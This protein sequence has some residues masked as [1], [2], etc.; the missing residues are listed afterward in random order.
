MSL[1]E[2]KQKQQTRRMI[3]IQ[4]MKKERRQA[5]TTITYRINIPWI[6]EKEI[7]KE[8]DFFLSF[9]FLLLFL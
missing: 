5:T 9:T 2:E 3:S 4:Y 7:I 8:I 6:L 1:P